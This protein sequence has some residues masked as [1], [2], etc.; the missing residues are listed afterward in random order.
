MEYVL[1]GVAL[2]AIVVSP[3]EHLIVAVAGMNVIFPGF[4][5]NRVVA[6]RRPD[7]VVAVASID[8]VIAARVTISSPGVIER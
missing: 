5:I 4:A 6:Y 3:A 8:H 2:D 7:R 1:P